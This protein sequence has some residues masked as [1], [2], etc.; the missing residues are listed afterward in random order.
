MTT[1]DAKLELISP[2]EAQ[3]YWEQ[4]FP[5]IAEILDTMGLRCKMD[6][7]HVWAW[8]LQ[9]RM[10][11]WLAVDDSTNEVVAFSLTEPLNYPKCWILDHFM[12]SVNPKYR[13]KV[14]LEEMYL[15]QEN[16]AKS[17]G[18]SG[19]QAHG[20]YGWK[21]FLKEHGYEAPTITSIKNFT[22]ERFH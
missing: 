12:S 19:I 17:Q 7:T 21:K 1:S 15:V 3:N 10:H 8:V 13:H 9:G 20:R 11:L 18:F 2:F 16:W 4:C 14:D 6:E 22:D 5:L